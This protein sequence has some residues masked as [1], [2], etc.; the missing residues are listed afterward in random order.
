LN[1]GIFSHCL[2]VSIVAALTAGTVYNFGYFAVFFII[3]GSIVPVAYGSLLTFWRF[4]NRTIIIIITTCACVIF[5]QRTY[6]ILVNTK[7]T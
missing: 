5:T 7:Q 2:N 6:N 4:T 1:F 3:F